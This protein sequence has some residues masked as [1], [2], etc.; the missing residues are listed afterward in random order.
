MRVNLISTAATYPATDSLARLASVLLRRGDHVRVHLPR[1]IADLPQ[2]LPDLIAHE[3][4]SSPDLLALPRFRTSDLFVYHCVDFDPILET[5]HGLERGVVVLWPQP[6]VA[7]DSPHALPDYLVRLASASDLVVIDDAPSARALQDAG[8]AEPRRLPRCT[9]GRITR[10]LHARPAGCR[11]F[12]RPGPP[13]QA[14][15]PHHAAG[16]CN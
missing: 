10:T 12:S 9:A 8:A 14:S 4:A 5:L 13:R 11:P 1:P 15:S 16:L 7:L 2:P 6:F 3:G